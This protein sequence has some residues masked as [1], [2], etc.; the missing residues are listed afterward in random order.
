MRKFRISINESKTDY[1]V[2][3]LHVFAA[4]LD[5]AC[6]DAKRL[7]GAD[8]WA[9][10]VDELLPDVWAIVDE[11]GGYDASEHLHYG[12]DRINRAYDRLGDAL[13]I[14]DEKAADD[15][16]DFYE[17]YLEKFAERYGMSEAKLEDIATD[18]R[19]VGWERD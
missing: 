3:E 9:H 10:V 16:G 13:A 14:G 2:R 4:T 1:T 6:M 15:F 11:N 12:V 17:F 7:V 5:N 8:R 18:V 19:F